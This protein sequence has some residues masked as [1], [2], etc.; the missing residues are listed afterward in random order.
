[1][2]QLPELELASGT[3]L[4]AD[5][6]LDVEDEAAVEAFLG[7]LARAE[8]APRVVVLGDLFE[9]WL[10]PAH[11]GTPGGQRVVD[12]LAARARRGR[13][14]DVV[15]GNRDFLLDEGFERAAGARVLRDGFVG[16]LPGGGRVVCVHGDELATRDH[17]YQRLR[18]VLRSR[19]L[20]WLAPRLPLGLA[21]ALARRLRRAS[22]RAVAAKPAAEKALQPAAAAEVL[23]GQGAGTV[24]CGHAH[25]FRDEAL[26]GE[27]RWLVLDA[28]GGRRD[29]L[30]VGAGGELRVR[31]SRELG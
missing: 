13:L 31:S 24:V 30:E 16:R 27:G 19:P 21:R 3:V 20:L 23:R 22:T 12:C 2:V 10:G 8:A 29:T 15:P 26:E 17:A 6:H 11:Q 1:M 14:F 7:F 5:L 18:R 9:Y 4:I 28:F 25:A